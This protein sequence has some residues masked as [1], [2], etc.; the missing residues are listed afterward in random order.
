MAVEDA[1]AITKGDAAMARSRD[2]I[3]LAALITG[4]MVAPGMAASSSTMHTGA[5]PLVQAQ[6]YQPE[7]PYY[8]PAPRAPRRVCWTEYRRVYVGYDRYGRR[9]YRRVPRR[10]CGYR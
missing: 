1:A 9:M 8:Q 7:R 5:A 6:Y 4:A 3:L 10:V 2:V